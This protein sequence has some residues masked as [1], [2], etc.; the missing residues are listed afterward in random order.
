[1]KV[2]EE[3]SHRV[4]V[5]TE[6]FS[7]ENNTT[8]LEFLSK[9]WPN[10]YKKFI[11][12]EVNN[13]L[14]GLNAPI[15]TDSVIKPLTVADRMG[16][17]VYRASASLIMLEAMK[18]ILPGH[19]PVIGQS[20]QD[21]YFY[22][23]REMKDGVPKEIIR[24]IELEMKKIVEENLKFE[25][26]SLHVN[27]V[28]KMLLEVEQ[29]EKVN[30]LR[31]HYEPQVRIVRVGNTFDLFHTPYAPSTG[32][33]DTFELA[34]YWPGMVLRFPAR[35]STKIT[36]K[37]N[38]YP[39]LFQTYMETRSWNSMLGV[40]NL[41][42]LNG[43]ILSNDIHNLI[44]ISEGLHEKK[45]ASI[46]D[47]IASRQ[48]EVKLILI[49]G[50]SSSGKTTFS[51][52]LA[53]QLQVNGIRPMTLE[54][55]NFFVEREQTPRDKNGEYD[56]ESID[57]IDIPLFNDVLVRLMDGETVKTP[58]FDFKKGGK[59]PKDK[60]IPKKLEKDAVL[61]VE[62]IHGLNDKLT[63]SVMGHRKFKIYISALTQLCIDDHNRIFTSDVRLIRRIVRDRNFRGY[64]AADTIKR[65]PSV[66]KGELKHIFPFQEKCDVMFNSAL[67][68]EP[69]VLKTVCE[70]ALLEVDPESESFSEAYR[71]LRFL[72]LVMPISKANVP[73]NSIIRE[74]I[75][76]SI[77][78][79]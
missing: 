62:G 45:I 61:I 28:K 77:F 1:M 4:L 11:A 75:G 25:I 8:V 3:K 70:R 38:Q 59:L 39:K 12:A 63:T 43:A 51:K 76:Q 79:Y 19:K 2:T 57:A 14:Y 36:G 48:P 15:R 67:F 72:R 69:G 54:M 30:L 52:R 60:W 16:T 35:G 64:S 40:Q 9:S 6:E 27:Q 26:E 5:G 34:S 13:R 32:Y 49:A 55:D 17:T 58:V 10:D 31:I 18:R 73:P 22:Q 20:I 53:I 33:I 66:R 50:P 47:T 78:H 29:P 56:F 68:Y 46:A 74:F 37:T 41:G 65:W 24:D 23:I 42:E 21:G 71:L 7:V 44:S